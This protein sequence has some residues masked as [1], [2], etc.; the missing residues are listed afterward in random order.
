MDRTTVLN[1]TANKPWLSIV[2]NSGY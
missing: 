2:C 1:L